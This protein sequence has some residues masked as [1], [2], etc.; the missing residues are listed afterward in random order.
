LANLARDALEQI[1]DRDERAKLLISLIDRSSGLLM[2]YHLV[3][4]ECSEDARAKRLPD[5][6]S[7]DESYGPELKRALIGRIEALQNSDAALR[8]PD[9]VG[10]LLHTWAKWG[11]AAHAGRWLVDN[12]SN[13]D[14]IW[15]FL[16][17]AVSWNGQIPERGIASVSIDLLT[18][19]IP[20]SELDEMIGDLRTG[21][22]DGRRRAFLAAYDRAHESFSE[23]TAKAE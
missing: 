18:K 13:H 20:L 14:L 11:D 12:R 22:L 19:F 4:P 7:T 16:F 6:F 10:A 8:T 5:N 21:E 3:L 17:T 2:P 9:S 15:G 1:K 23:G